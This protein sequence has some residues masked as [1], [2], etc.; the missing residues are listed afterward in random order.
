MAQKTTDLTGKRF[1]RWLVI[2]RINHKDH[3]N[4]YRWECLCD[5]GNTKEVRSDTLLAGVSRS[6]GCLRDEILHN[7]AYKSINNLTGQKFGNLLVLRKA[8]YRPKSI[9]GSV[10]WLCLCDCGSFVILPSHSLSSGN[11]KSC[12]CY[13][14]NF[15]ILHGQSRTK[16]Y[17][18][19]AVAKR[20]E[21]E[22]LLDSTWDHKLVNALLDFQPCCVICGMTDQEHQERYG[23]R[24]HIDHVLPL[25][26]GYGLKPGNAVVLCQHHNDSKRNKDLN[27]LPEEW[28]FKII[29]SA[30]HFKYFWEDQK[31]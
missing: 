26:K 21:Q 9:K 24:L 31:G 7:H 25:S 13:R 4:K 23:K 30:Y 22:K 2:K 10:C 19:A 1:G 6:C 5:C 27:E 16:E 12:G 29:R 14:K 15:R 11:T 28:Q 8:K 17:R 3:R 18:R 20:R